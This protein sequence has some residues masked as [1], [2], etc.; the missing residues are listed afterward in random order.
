MTVIFF[1]LTF[2]FSCKYIIQR[3]LKVSRLIVLIIVLRSSEWSLLSEQEKRE[4]EL[5][6]EDDG[7]FW[8]VIFT[9]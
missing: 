2:Q 9:F 3:L 6:F 4:M 1:N 8:W 7:E 5:T